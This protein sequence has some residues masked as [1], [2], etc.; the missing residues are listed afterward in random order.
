MHPVSLVPRVIAI[1]AG[2]IHSIEFATD[3]AFPPRNATYAAIRTSRRYPNR[4]FKV[5][6]EGVYKIRLPAAEVAFW[7][8]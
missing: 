7:L 8:Q 2:A 5:Y 4:R 6:S 1:K 3:A